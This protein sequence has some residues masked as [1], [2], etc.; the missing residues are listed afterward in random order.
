MYSI[1]CSTEGEYYV[2]IV[3][4]NAYNVAVGAPRRISHSTVAARGK[5]VPIK[6]H[7]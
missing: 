4:D 5:K 7:I 1:V 3:Q 2:I 6:W